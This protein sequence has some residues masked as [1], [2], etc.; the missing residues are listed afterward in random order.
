M[1]GQ[2][3]SPPTVMTWTTWTTYSSSE[4][5]SSDPFG[6]FAQ[7]LAFFDPEPSAVAP[8]DAT[9]LPTAA[10]ATDPTTTEP[11]AT[12]ASP[13]TATATIDAART[14][15]ASEPTHAVAVC[16]PTKHEMLELALEIQSLR[17][18]AQSACSL[19]RFLL[20]IL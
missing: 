10:A 19:F 5:P 14:K 12:S 7:F 11:T 16:K 9:A 6:P 20:T 15:A 4:S 3:I 18:S 2:A 1:L 8:T 13:A 17:V